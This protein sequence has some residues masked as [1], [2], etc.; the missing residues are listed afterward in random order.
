MIFQDVLR[1][2]S[3]AAA[4][5]T[6]NSSENKLLRERLAS[7]RK[8]ISV[9]GISVQ[10]DCERQKLLDLSG[11]L[12]KCQNLLRSHV[13]K[14]AELK[15]KNDVQVESR[16]KKREEAIERIKNAANSYER[17]GLIVPRSR[18]YDNYTK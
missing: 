16:N 11:R 18:L 17:L 8:K 7:C 2:V 15:G 9:S 3:E 5:Q 6:A 14:A 1:Q 10:F 4:Y 13:E 12:K